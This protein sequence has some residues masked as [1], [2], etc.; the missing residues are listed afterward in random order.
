MIWWLCMASTHPAIY[1][2]RLRKNY[3]QLKYNVLALIQLKSGKWKISLII[4]FK[5]VIRSNLNG[6]NNCL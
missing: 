1:P 6:L 3:L 4:E 5:K 2:N